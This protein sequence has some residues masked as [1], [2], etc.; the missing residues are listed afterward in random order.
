MILPQWQLLFHVR[1]F[2]YLP[3]FT[4]ADLSILVGVWSLPPPTE[5]RLTRAI[6][7]QLRRMGL[8]ITASGI[9]G[10][11]INDSQKLIDDEMFAD[12]YLSD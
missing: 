11:S 9:N 1:L 2:I 10:S 6:E 7:K 3:H 4:I 8:P 12:D 5:S